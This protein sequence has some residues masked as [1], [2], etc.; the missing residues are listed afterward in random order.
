MRRSGLQKAPSVHGHYPPIGT[1]G[2]SAFRE[3]T[4]SG[5]AGD[6]K[7]LRT[8]AHHRPAA[9]IPTKRLSPI[10]LLAQETTIT[11]REPA[12]PEPEF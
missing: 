10:T 8:A 6:S 5:H 3:I 4:K 9:L 2:Q 12:E 1:E 11:N 7:R